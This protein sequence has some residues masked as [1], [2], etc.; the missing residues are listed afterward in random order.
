VIRYSPYG[1]LL[2]C[3]RGRF[4]YDDRLVELVA[5]DGLDLVACR[6]LAQLANQRAKKLLSWEGGRERK[7]EEEGKG[8]W[9]GG[10]K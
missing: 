3:S 4:Y 7:R 8:G 6:A 2:T 5:L 1:K 10:R 9:E